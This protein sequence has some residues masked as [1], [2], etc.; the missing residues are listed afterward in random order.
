MRLTVR[1]SVR[2]DGYLAA[3]TIAIVQRTLLKGV[4]WQDALLPFAGFLSLVLDGVMLLLLAAS[5]LQDVLK[6]RRLHHLIA[7]LTLGLLAVSAAVTRQTGLLYSAALVLLARDIPYARIVRTFFRTALA[8]L[9]LLMLA[10]LTGLTKRSVPNPEYSLGYAMGM[11]HP[12]NFASAVTV[13]LFSWAYLRRWE[14]RS[15]TILACLAVGFA[16]YRYTISR[17][18]LVIVLVYCLALILYEMLARFRAKNAL[19][20]IRLG[21]I[22]LLA[23]SVWLMLYADQVFGLLGL[24][25][26]TEFTPLAGAMARFVNAA[27]LYEQNGLRLFGSY[28][29]FRSLRVA[30]QT[31]QEAVI[32]DSAYLY[33]VIS[34]GVAATGVMLWLFGRSIRAQLRKK[35]YVLL[36]TMGVFLLSGLMERFAL[37]AAM[38]FALLSAFSALEQD[39]QM[40]KN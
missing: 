2:E 3:L 18:A 27:A 29:E 34:Q 23:S 17:T 15:F 10:Q 9:I 28:I 7:A 19:K 24:D 22:V 39:A 11:A 16:V 31:N 20:L 12:N 33:L 5:F 13:L 40:T 36:I 8:A 21:F 37:D 38:N 25:G 14:S 26:S 32:L 30:L 1:L 6:R 35:Q 4:D